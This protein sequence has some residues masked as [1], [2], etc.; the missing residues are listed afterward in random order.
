MG[1]DY[2][3]FSK[4]KVPEGRYIK[5]LP[6]SINAARDVLYQE[7]SSSN[8][9]MFDPKRS[10]DPY[11]K[12]LGYGIYDLQK[13]YDLSD[14]FIEAEDNWLKTKDSNAF[15]PDKL[16]SLYKYAKEFDKTADKLDISIYK[17]KEACDDRWGDR[18]CLWRSCE[19]YFTVIEYLT[20]DEGEERRSK[21]TTL[22]EAFKFITDVIKDYQCLFTEFRVR[23]EE[24][25]FIERFVYNF[26][27]DARNNSD[28]LDHT[29]HPYTEL[30]DEEKSVIKAASEELT[31]KDFFLNAYYFQYVHEEIQG[32][33]NKR[34]DV[35]REIETERVLAKTQK[36]AEDIFYKKYPRSFKSNC[37]LWES[38][39][40]LSFQNKAD[41]EDCERK[42]EMYKEK[43]E[44]LKKETPKDL[45][46][47]ETGFDG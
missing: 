19:K 29:Y 25:F 11:F 12:H 3:T 24:D 46:K 38:Y 36:E 15:I 6:Y 42:I 47:V 43:L 16:L 20:S 33:Y 27:P 5:V 14:E 28:H 7:P 9:Y 34:S 13:L 22:K 44:R 10:N 4:T 37:S 1:K 31:K 32:R 17:D 30:R 2:V 35:S 41:I 23:A 8:D 45:V 26:T 40:P 21:F 39:K 18:V